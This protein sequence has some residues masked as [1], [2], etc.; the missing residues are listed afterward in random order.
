MRAQAIQRGYA[1]P[2]SLWALLII[3]TIITPSVLGFEFLQE[4]TQTPLDVPQISGPIAI[5]ANLDEEAWQQALVMELN[6]DFDPGENIP[7]PVR[8][9]AFIMYDEENLYTA[10]KCYDDDPAAIQAHFKDREDFWHDD[11]VN[12]HIDTYN[13]ERRNYTFGTN[14]LGIQMDAVAAQGQGFDWSWDGIWESD[15]RVTDWGY[16]V[17][18]AIP[19]NQIRFQRTEGDQIWGLDFWRVYPREVLRFIGAVPQ[20]P[21]NMCWRCQMKKVSGF[22]GIKPTRNLGGTPTLTAGRT[23]TRDPFPGGEFDPEY[24]RP[25]IGFS[26]Q[27]GITQ[28][29]T[30]NATVNPDFSQVEADAYQLD[31]NQPWALYYRE[32]R[33]FFTEGMDFFRT[34]KNAIYTRA[35]REPEWGLKLTGKAGPH[36][37][38]GY[39]VQDATS[40]ILFPS[41]Q[42]SWTATLD[43]PS[44]ASV[45][46]YKHDFGSSYTLGTLLTDRRGEDYANTLV[47]LDNH[48]RLGD[49]DEF[50]LQILHSVT[51]YPLELARE[52]GQDSSRFQGSY[53]AFEYDRDTRN[54]YW[55]LDYDYVSDGLRAEL[56]FINRVGFQNLEGGYHH[57]WLGEPGQWWTRLDVGTNFN[58]YVDHDNNLLQRGG[59]VSFNYRG[60]KRSG[61]NIY[62]YYREEAF[63][64]STF[65][66][67]HPYLHAWFRP[68]PDMELSFLTRLGDHIDYA[69][70][71]LGKRSHWNPWI[72]YDVGQ[73]LQLYVDHTFERLEVEEERVYT[74]N[75]TQGSAEY[76]F[77]L[78]SFLRLIYQYVDYQYNTEMYS[79]DRD[80]ESQYA[81]MQ[82]LFSY[83][84]NPQTVFFLGYSGNHYGS[85][86]YDLIQND[87]SVFMKLGYAFSL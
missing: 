15:G 40:N 60:I 6:Y 46:R 80:P 82:L 12:I 87:R 37:M 35:L 85:Q 67:I 73:R 3:Q 77:S 69:N 38:G 42:G 39:I 47:G 13:D 66:I 83:K 14:P 52:N 64:D 44:T 36:T 76:Q 16:V 78:R 75:I 22:E 41:T 50:Q 54:D 51:E 30:L 63:N 71:R 21:D 70:T 28:N 1:K 23:D 43:Q 68:I 31:I 10:F 17:E 29:F 24:K 45:M 7:P 61:V 20:D 8:T 48:Y 49:S 11:H 79:D 27:W 65:K 58:Y 62:L 32:K 72:V 4:S 53:I 86:E 59:S 19:F 56:G 84:V 33:P 5:D 57:N 55:W 81:F 74:A 34:L 2:C 18:I 25:D 26:G 9:E